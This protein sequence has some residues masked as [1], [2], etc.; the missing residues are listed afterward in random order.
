MQERLVGDAG[1]NWV[2]GALA[3]RLDAFAE[4]SPAGYKFLA[5]FH[6]EGN[7]PTF[8]DLVV[9]DPDRGSAEAQAAKHLAGAKKM[10]MLI[11]SH[12]DLKQLKLQPGQ[13][14]TVNGI[15]AMT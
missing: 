9:Y 7:P 2:K 4:A 12:D 1:D 8:K 3:E 10:E 5:E 11:L 13:M 15:V 6:Q 14:R